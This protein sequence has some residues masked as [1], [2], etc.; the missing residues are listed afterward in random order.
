MITNTNHHS[1]QQ[2]QGITS[3][4]ES[5][6]LIN[7]ALLDAS[8]DVP[9]VIMANNKNERRERFNRV[10][11][12]WSLGFLSPF[13][14]LPL[15]NRLALKYVAKTYKNFFNKENKIIEI[16]NAMLKTEKSAKNAIQQMASKNNFNAEELAS[17]CGGYENLR[18]KL[19]NAKNAVLSFDFAFTAG[20]LGSIG[21]YNN[22][23][24]KKKTGR[25]GFSAEFNM[26]DKSVTD[27]RARRYEKTASLRAASF[28]ALV[29]GLAAL[30]I[31]IK[32]G[33]TN[34]AQKGFSGLLNKYAHKFN[35]DDGICMKR[36]P[37]FLAL[38]CAYYGV[39]SASRNQTELK[40]NLVRSTASC[41][42]FFG[43]DLIIGSTLARLSDKYLKTEILDKNAPKTL[44]NKLVP[45][46]R[47]LKDLSG[48]S[49]KIGTGLFWIN[50]ALLSL[51]LGFGVPALL[52]KMIKRDVEKDVNQN[53]PA[54]NFQTVNAG[55]NSETF[56]QFMKTSLSQA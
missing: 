21:Y 54:Q 2:F 48:S 46:T 51:S 19:I 27:E 3:F 56:K 38:M 17:K 24:T 11:I 34:N 40:D 33:L 8:A 55:L 37:M 35:Y 31:F 22:Y 16:S 4:I 47:H 20:S 41:A 29:G 50:M 39:S 9:V 18:K 32:K 25:K 7:K 45:P 42:V 5:R 23:L 44:L 53:A 13:I 12:G 1:P 52:N 43:G 36:L 49:R 15:T 30:P 10:A 26:A 6:V 14:T 28:A